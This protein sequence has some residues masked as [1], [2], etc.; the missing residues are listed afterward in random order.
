MTGLVRR[1]RRRRVRAGRVVG[2]N[3]LDRPAPIPCCTFRGSVT[4]VRVAR[5]VRRLEDLFRRPR[6]SRPARPR[7]ARRRSDRRAPASGRR[8]PSTSARGVLYV[9]TGDN[10]SHPATATSDAVVA[11]DLEDRAASSGRSRRRRT[12]STTRRAAAAARTAPRTRAPTTTSAPRRCWSARRAAR[13][14]LVAGQKSGVVYALD[15]ANAGKLLWQARVGKGGTNGGV[16]WGMASD[17][18]N[19]YAAVSDVVRLQNVAGRSADRLRAA[20]P[21]RRAAASR[22]STSRTANASGSRRHAVRSA[23]ARVQPRAAGRRDGDTRRRVLR[24]DRRPPARVLDGRRQAALGLRYGARLRDRER[25]ARRK[26]GSLDG[27]GPVVVDG[28]VFVNSGYP[29]FGGM[30][31]NVLLAFGVPE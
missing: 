12:T 10:Y 9:T 1:A 29:R 24:L 2:R 8:R 18:R 11:L 26:G 20:R 16:Q 6:R 7:S 27:A 14:I 25:R 28:M 15:P 3:A 4:A 13:D 30:P 23:A 19:V 17:G 31:G 21:E 22:R 5:R